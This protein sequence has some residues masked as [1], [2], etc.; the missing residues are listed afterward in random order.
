M[1]T[2]NEHHLE[3]VLNGWSE[4]LN[5]EGKIFSR[6]VFKAAATSTLR[7]IFLVFAPKLK[8]LTKR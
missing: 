4:N 3:N 2:Q 6:R 5:F 7:V 1:E 8:M